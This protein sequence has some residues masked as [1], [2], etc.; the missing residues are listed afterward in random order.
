MFGFVLWNQFFFSFTAWN[1][2]NNVWKMVWN[3]PLSIMFTFVH[4]FDGWI[5]F[6]LC[7]SFSILF[8]FYS[9]NAFRYIWSIKN[10]NLNLIIN[11]IY[12]FTSKRHTNYKRSSYELE[13]LLLLSL[14]VSF[15]EF[16]FFW[17][18]IQNKI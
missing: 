4:A 13:I 18:W 14:C 15:F 7:S 6:E 1:Q 11:Q 5:W 2:R 17:N 12:H 9:S 10:I 16:F 8:F 3:I